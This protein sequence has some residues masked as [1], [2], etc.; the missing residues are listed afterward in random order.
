MSELKSEI[1]VD[2][3]SPLGEKLELKGKFELKKPS[4]DK[5]VFEIDP[6][7]GTISNEDFTLG[8]NDL[9]IPVLVLENEKASGFGYIVDGITY[10]F[11]KTNPNKGLKFHTN[12]G[13][14]PENSFDVNRFNN[15]TLGNIQDGF[16]SINITPQDT[17][18]FPTL[19]D[20]ITINSSQVSI[21]S[22]SFSLLQTQKDKIILCFL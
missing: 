2:K 11:N 7:T 8:H 10:N 12:T 5:V 3:I 9:D 20:S 6:D 1:V 18:N 22:G 4:D 17:A 19:K 21:V 15:I 16:G 14:N 13:N